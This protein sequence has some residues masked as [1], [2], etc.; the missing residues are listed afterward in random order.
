MRLEAHAVCHHFFHLFNSEISSVPFLDKTSDNI[1]GCLSLVFFENRIG[2]RIE[3]F[4]TIVKGQPD[5]LLSRQ[6]IFSQGLVGF[7]RSQEIVTCIY[8]GLDLRF[9]IVRSN[10]EVGVR[11]LRWIHNMNSMVHEDRNLNRIVIGLPIGCTLRL[12]RLGMFLIGFR[13]VW[14]V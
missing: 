10:N 4:V 2:N 14:T 12:T 8:H 3:V 1:I 9:K 13:L 5:N 6:C 11:G 7:F